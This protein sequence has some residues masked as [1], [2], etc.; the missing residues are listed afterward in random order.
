[1]RALFARERTSSLV[2]ESQPPHKIVNL[3]FTITNQNNKLTVSWGSEPNNLINELCEMRPDENSAARPVH[4]INLTPQRPAEPP[5]LPNPPSPDEDSTLPVVECAMGL[6]FTCLGQSQLL[7]VNKFTQ[8]S[9]ALD[10]SQLLKVKKN[11]Q[12]KR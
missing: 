3:F 11:T 8:H 9:L 10:Q 4:L 2:S 6:A 12:H 5:A 1:M 7:K